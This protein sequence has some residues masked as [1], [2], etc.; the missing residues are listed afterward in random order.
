MCVNNIAASPHAALSSVKHAST[1]DI[2]VLEARDIRYTIKK[3]YLKYCGSG[4]VFVQSFG[5]NWIEH[6]VVLID[7]TTR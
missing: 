4:R 7:L 6:I 2:I 1:I 5:R 3:L